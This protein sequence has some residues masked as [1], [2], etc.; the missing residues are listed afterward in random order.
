MF[1]DDLFGSKGGGRDKRRSFTPTQKKEIFDR[2]NGKCAIC[3]KALKLASTQYDHVKAW[4][5]NGSTNVKNGRALCSN[6][7]DE[8]THKDRLKKLETKP[9]KPSTSNPLD[10]KL[11]DMKM[12]K[13]KMPKGKGGFGPF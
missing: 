4:S 5:E 7:H 11:P 6:C 8:K 1:G 2:Q 10:V 3:G 13:M 12:P 9:K